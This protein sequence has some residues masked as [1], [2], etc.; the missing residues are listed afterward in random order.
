MAT[1]TF[2]KSAAVSGKIYIVIQ[3]RI[4]DGMLKFQGIGAKQNRDYG[5]SDSCDLDCLPQLASFLSK[6]E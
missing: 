1:A 4:S 2:V 6:N 3:A 5:V